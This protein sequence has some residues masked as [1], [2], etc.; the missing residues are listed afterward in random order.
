MNTVENRLFRRQMFVAAFTAMLI[1][2]IPAWGS[3]YWMR[4]KDHFKLENTV[5]QEDF[6]KLQL[7]ME[8]KNRSLESIALSNKQDIGHI[9]KLIEEMREDQKEIDKFLLKEFKVRD[10]IKN[11]LPEY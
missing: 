10:T 7:L 5:S 8:A 2:C 1:I 4:T 3:I 11:I 6:F 9:D